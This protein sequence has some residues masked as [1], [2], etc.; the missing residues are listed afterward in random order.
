MGYKSRL[1]IVVVLA[2]L[3][4]GLPAWYFGW[5]KGRKTPYFST[6]HLAYSSQRASLS[7]LP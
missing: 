1:R 4:D 5:M 7:A 6:L 3:G 2:T